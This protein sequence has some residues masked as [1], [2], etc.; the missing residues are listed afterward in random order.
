[1]F[2]LSITTLE[3]IFMYDNHPGLIEKS[4]MRQWV[5]LPEELKQAFLLQSAT[6]ASDSALF[7]WFLSNILAKERPLQIICCTWLLHLLDFLQPR[8]IPQP[9]IFGPLKWKL[10]KS[11]YR[12]SLKFG[13]FYVSSWVNA[14]WV[15]VRMHSH[16]CLVPVSFY[17]LCSTGLI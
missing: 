5:V 11:Y 3:H 2:A 9:L 16:G 7:P 15:F 10:G 12:A 8:S 6:K 14:C 17:P 1:M 4:Q 13:L